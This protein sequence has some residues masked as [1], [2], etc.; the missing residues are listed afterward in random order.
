MDSNT[1]S[2]DV[3]TT[4]AALKAAEAFISGFEDDASQAGV[5]ELLATVRGAMAL[6]SDAIVIEPRRWTRSSGTYSD[7]GEFALTPQA[8]WYRMRVQ[9]EH[10][11][12]LEPFK[13]FIKASHYDDC[14]R[15][16]QCA[17]PAVTN[18][19]GDLVEVRA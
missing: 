15:L 3:C 14:G 9:R 13:T 6:P 2:A 16:W 12:P 1:P 4:Y 18:D 19:F 7:D 10:G 5:A 8:M 17:Y 11:W